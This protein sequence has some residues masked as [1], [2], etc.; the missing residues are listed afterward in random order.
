MKAASAY[1]VRGARLGRLQSNRHSKRTSADR[2]PAFSPHTWVHS[3]SES[4]ADG[5]ELDAVVGKAV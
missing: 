5:L 2:H 4:A 1:R 3:P